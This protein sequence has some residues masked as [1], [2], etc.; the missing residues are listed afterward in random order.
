MNDDSI[1]PNDEIDRLRREIDYLKRKQSPAN[2]EDDNLKAGMMN[3]SRSINSL[4]KIFK[5]ASDDLKLD[6][7]DAMLV[8][9]KLDKI[10][11]RLDKIEVQNEKIAKGIVAIADMVEDIQPEQSA[12]Q[13]SYQ[14]Q[15]SSSQPPMGP[16]QQSATE[17]QPQQWPSYNVPR[18]DDK[19]KNILNFKI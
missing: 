7:H 3:L 18:Q 6:T 17:Q 14:Q 13:P 12:S 15:V 10:I 5:D 9:Q 8:S 4:M 2:S 1:L 11:E 16:M 19:K